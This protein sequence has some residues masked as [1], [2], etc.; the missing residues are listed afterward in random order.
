MQMV[1]RENTYL[2]LM[3]NIVF[4]FLYG[5]VKYI[6]TPLGEL[7]R[8]LVLKLFL[9]KIK[10]IWIKDNATFWFPDKISIGKSTSINEMVTINGGGGVEIGD[11][12]LI[13]HGT[14]IVSDSHSFDDLTKQ[15]HKQSKH[16]AKVIIGNNVF[17]G[18][19]VT[20]LPGVKIGDGAVIGAGSVVTK[21]V[22]ENAIV[23]GNPAKIIRYR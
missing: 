4:F 16:K 20:V 22:P 2:Y 21:D 8:Y 18:C 15:I 9:K 3:K 12:V 5:L 11:Y 10:T 7:S 19:N 6:P 14:S 23:C 13:G 1:H 17:F